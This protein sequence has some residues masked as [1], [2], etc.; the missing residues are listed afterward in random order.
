MS[1]TIRGTVS[2]LSQVSILEYNKR[3]V[4]HMMLSWISLMMPH[5]LPSHSIQ[6]V[7]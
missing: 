3:W 7:Q 4:E 2:S 5:L 6:N 1:L